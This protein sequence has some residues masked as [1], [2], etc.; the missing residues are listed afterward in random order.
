MLT[1]LNSCA[2]TYYARG[3]KKYNRADY[4]DAARYFE[5]ALERKEIPDAR[6]KLA[7]SY[8]LANDTWKARQ[9]YGQVVNNEQAPSENWV[10]YAKSLIMNENY[11]E[12]LVWL[13]KYLHANP[14]DAIAADLY[15]TSQNAAN[16][17]PDTLS[18]SIERIKIPGLRSV[19]SP[20]I[21]NSGI[22][23][24]ADKEPE[25]TL[26]E[27]K[28]GWTGATF[29]DLYYMERDGQD[30]WKTPQP[31]AGE[32]NGLYH[33]GPAAISPDG[34]TIYFTRN[35]YQKKK[36]G[37][38]GDNENNLKLFSSALVNGIWATPEELPFNSDEYSAGHP[39]TSADGTTLY[40]ISD[41]P[42]GF[43]GTD[44]Y[45]S[46]KE[47]NG[48]SKPENL[49]SKI[50]TKGNEM[51]P[52]LFADSVLYFSSDA[53][54]SAGG[55]DIFASYYRD[56][57]WSEPES[58][59]YPVNTSKDDFGL[60][61]DTTGK[62]GYLSSNRSGNDQLYSFRKIDPVFNLMVT[63]KIKNIGAEITDGWIKVVNKNTGSEQLA[64][65]DNNGKYHLRLE[66]N[67]DY[68]VYAYKNNYFTK[69]ID[70][71]TRN[72]ASSED[73][74]I[75]FE[76]EEIIIEKPIVLDNIY[77]D[78]NKWNIR[79]DAAQELD[80]LVTILEDNPN[81]TIELS[82]HT[83]ARGQDKYNL[84]LSDKRARSAVIYVVSKGI[85]QERIESKGYGETMLVNHCVNN[86]E[87]PEEEHEKN[88]RTEFKVINITNIIQQF[89]NVEVREK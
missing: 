69:S 4:S 19:F 5:K 84:V 63:I 1:L 42:G 47:E 65:A 86:V 67:S 30:N 74:E 31:L 15:F 26:L 56:K 33:D 44:I 41:K 68:K 50:N 83:D 57:N 54:G 64:Y 14:S 77:Y 60:V 55:L 34:S 23:F 85:K 82:S 22:I 76:I 52:F 66:P 27:K 46:R 18:Y 61:L 29:L 37:R 2:D 20:A 89:T 49:G 24:S 87:C 28:H 62:S 80:K 16:L 39:T 51:F 11:E 7:H 13:E 81:I 53:H 21:Y 25:N 32:V 6:I 35:N 3:V 8:R 17:K 43:G 45:F 58:L 71:S 9:A 78:L 48:W 38:S 10:Y 72:R 88:R 36:L 59:E 40:F 73:F 79:P 75:E 70:I 12:A